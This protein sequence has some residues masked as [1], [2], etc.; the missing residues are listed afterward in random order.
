ML[1]ERAP[2]DPPSR[3]PLPVIA[4]VLSTAACAVIAAVGER[5]GLP[6]IHLAALAPARFWSGEVWRIVTW[7]FVDGDPLS[8]AVRCAILWWLGRDLSRAW[9]AA[10]FVWR[11]LVLA[12][13]TA[14]AVCLLA[15]AVAPLRR[16]AWLGGWPMVEALTISWAAAYPERD[17]WMLLVVRLRGRLLIAAVV[18]LTLLS[19]L[20][21]GFSSVAPH[22]LAE[23][24]ALLD[25]S[26]LGPTLARRYARWRLRRRGPRLRIVERDEDPPDRPR[27][28]R[29]VN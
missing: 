18:T 14:V 15:L 16:A 8:L 7:V 10:R 26:D 5:S 2:P 1:V 27:P 28:P 17:V 23:A 11:Y 6:L 12:S 3:A 20:F 29:W 24:L 19:G 13:T 25:A 22:L 9:G 4:L 21:W